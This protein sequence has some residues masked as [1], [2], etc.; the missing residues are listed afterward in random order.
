MAKLNFLDFTFLQTVLNIPDF[1]ADP[2]FAKNPQIVA[3]DMRSYAGV[4][5]AY[6]IQGSGYASWVIFP[7]DWPFTYIHFFRY[8]SESVSLGSLCVMSLQKTR[9]PLSMMQQKSLARFADIA[10]HAM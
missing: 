5:L 3:A 9:P 2:R 4:P 6:T 10:M 8:Y 7:P 1:F